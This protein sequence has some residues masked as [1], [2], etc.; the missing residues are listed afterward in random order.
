[1]RAHFDGRVFV[2]HGRVDLPTGTDVELDVRSTQGVNELDVEERRQRRR[3]LLGSM[4][5][6]VK[7]MSPDFDEPLDFNFDDPNDPL[8]GGK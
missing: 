8:L 1:M 6:L 2:P 7:Y 3:H 4:P 5:G